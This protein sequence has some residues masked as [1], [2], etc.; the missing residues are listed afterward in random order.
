MLGQFLI[1]YLKSEIIFKSGV[2]TWEIVPD[3]FALF[4]PQNAIKIFRHL[5]KLRII[6]KIRIGPVGPVAPK[7]L[8]SNSWDD[9]DGPGGRHYFYNFFFYILRDCSFRYFL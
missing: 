3:I 2:V 1:I 4:F 5:A 7:L 6:H 9:P 8:T